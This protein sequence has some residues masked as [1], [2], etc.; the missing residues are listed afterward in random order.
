MGG[1]S[2]GGEKEG[3]KKEE[4]EECHQHCFFLLLFCCLKI[5]GVRIEVMCGM[6]VLNNV[7]IMTPPLNL[8][9]ETI[10]HS[11]Q[12]GRGGSRDSAYQNPETSSN[13]YESR[14]ERGNP[15]FNFEKFRRTRNHQPTW[16]S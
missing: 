13:Q 11:K 8:Q 6:C 2:K 5:L 10:L 12:D 14:R 7:S 16:K 4:E 3:R 15:N 9:K 1:V